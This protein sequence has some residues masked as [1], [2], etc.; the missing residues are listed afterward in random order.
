MSRVIVTGGSGFVGGHLVDKLISLGHKVSVIDNQS[1][2]ETEKFYF[3]SDASYFKFDICNKELIDPLF[4]NADYVFHLAAESRIQPAILNPQRA[5][6]VN[7]LGTLNILELSKKYKIKRIMYSSTSSVYGLTKE[8]PTTEEANIDCI[9]PYAHSK[10][11]GE[12]LFR[13]YSKIHDVDSVIFRYFN[14][15]GERSPI[16]GQ[17][18]PVVGIFLN[19]S[20]KGERLTIVGDGCKK[21]DFIHVYDIVDANIKAMNHKN[22][23]KST[24]INIGSGTNMTIKEIADLISI[25]Q[26]NIPIREGEAENTLADINKAK[27]ILN[28]EPKTFIENWIKSKK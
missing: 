19:Q 21:R 23:L 17:Y 2:T 27:S 8:L 9:N 24:T 11:L 22:D 14:V 4:E 10:F 26:I 20:K 12:E 18:A 16:K 1:S 6:S 25:N 7:V 28:F 13:Y 15:F 3:N 5:Y